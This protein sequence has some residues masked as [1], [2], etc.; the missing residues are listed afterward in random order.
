MRAGAI[1]RLL[2]CGC[3]AGLCGLPAQRVQAS[4]S[5]WYL[6]PEVPHV[7]TADQL[8]AVV[9]AMRRS[10]WDLA[11][12][13]FTGQ[14]D[15]RQRTFRQDLDEWY[16]NPDTVK[17][18]DELRASARAQGAAHKDRALRKTLDA[19]TALVSVEAHRYG[20]IL[21][22]WHYQTEFTLHQRLLL[23]LQQR[24]PQESRRA[25]P[26]DI[27]SDLAD[28]GAQMSKALSAAASAPADQS[29][30]LEKLSETTAALLRRF[31]DE[32][33]RQGA[34]V[35][36]SEHARGTVPASLQRSEVC[37]PP[38]T[39]TSGHAKPSLDPAT[40]VPPDVF[41]PPEMRGND[42]EGAVVV[43]ARISLAGCVTNV[44]VNVSSGAPALDEAA[45]H[46]ALQARFLP[47]ER[48][49][50]AVEAPMQF[51]V[52]FRLIAD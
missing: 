23:D 41:Y 27:A 46:W 36:V 29:A 4:E 3:V 35:S 12:Q 39:R 15:V 10:A 9:E 45:L 11:G 7:E 5:Q 28:L 47:A 21:G 25:P 8:D 40:T 52:R 34:A 24:L 51:R 43:E 1:V 16:V 44:Q 17:R 14:P 42:V 32:R 33:S 18:I 50:H 37:P 48:D 26:P 49:A 6:Q 2:A 38:A 22:Y 13:E 20:L 30:E 19:A 31:N